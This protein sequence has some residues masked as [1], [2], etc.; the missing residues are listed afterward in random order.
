MAKRLADAAPAGEDGAVLNLVL[1]GNVMKKSLVIVL[2]VALIVGSA[3]QA[4]DVT[5]Q[6]IVDGRLYL[7]C[8]DGH[9]RCYDVTSRD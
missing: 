2:L 6:P 9:I 1:R 8:I 7:R 5:N 4:Q 3:L